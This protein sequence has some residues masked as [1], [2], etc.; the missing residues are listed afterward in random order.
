MISRF[1]LLDPLKGQLPWWPYPNSANG[2]LWRVRALLHRRTVEE[3]S[4]IAAEAEA[5][6]DVFF[7]AERDHAIAQITA[8][9]RFDLF[10]DGQNS[11]SGIRS[12]AYDEYS[13]NDRDNT[14]QLEA[15]DQALSNMFDPSN[16][17]AVDV[18]EYECLAA[19]AFTKLDSLARS[20]LFKY[21]GEGEGVL[22]KSG[23][24]ATHF[25]YTIAASYLVEATDAVG[26]A[27][28]R[29]ATQRLS[30]KYEEKIGKIRDSQDLHAAIRA[31]L[32]QQERQRR[33]EEAAARNDSRHEFNRQVKAKVL[34]WFAEDP[35]KFPSAEKAAKYFCSR[36]SEENI[37]R[38]QR[39][40][41]D[42]IR[43]YAKDTGLR[44]RA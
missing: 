6:I 12:E 21:D 29:K 42:W 5:L 26:R 38:E 15:L 1:N 32:V 20:A 9:K 22:R 19:F 28:L 2:I 11:S 34:S 17:E 24:G 4:E 35:A 27:E 10:E 13:I 37:E 41:A 31:E 30:Q 7:D 43:T 14:T 16:L 44:W 36:L 3:V 23:S 40:V 33:Q 18:E 25:D 39:T 8:D